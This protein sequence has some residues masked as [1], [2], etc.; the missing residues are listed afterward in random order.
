MTGHLTSMAY[1][2]VTSEPIVREAS[3]AGGERDQY[4]LRCDLVLRGVSHPQTEELGAS[5]F[6]TLTPSRMPIVQLN[7]VLDS[8]A[9]AKK[10]KNAQACRQRRADS[11]PFIVTAD[12]VTQ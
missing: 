10:T 3:T 4:D 2:N 7:V 5:V 1:S 12:G 11:T 9:Q 6:V 8:L